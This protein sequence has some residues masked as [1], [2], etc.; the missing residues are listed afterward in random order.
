M[1][2]CFTILLCLTVN[3]LVEPR[4]KVMLFITPTKGNKGDNTTTVK[5]KDGPPLPIWDAVFANVTGWVL[6]HGKYAQG[7]FD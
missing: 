7:R 5:G 3:E 4:R 2:A 6:L 1:R